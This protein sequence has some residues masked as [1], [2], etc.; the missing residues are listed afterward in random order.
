MS[1]T[2][3]LVSFV[4]QILGHFCETHETP[5]DPDA[6]AIDPDPDAGAID[7]DPDTGARKRETRRRQRRRRKT[8]DHGS[9]S[10][11]PIQAHAKNETRGNTGAALFSPY[12][13]CFLRIF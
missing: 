12:S 3:L 6:G 8:L 9:R 5:T 7:A 1:L 11:T 13:L 2:F 10:A 4:S